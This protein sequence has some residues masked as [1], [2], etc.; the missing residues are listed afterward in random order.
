MC[1]SEQQH[2][3]T[4]SRISLEKE[5]PAWVLRYPSRFKCAT[6]SLAC[7]MLLFLI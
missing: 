5:S 3:Y 6:Q 7:H 4:H 1:V 2:E